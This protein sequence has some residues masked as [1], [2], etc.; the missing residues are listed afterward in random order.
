MHHTWLCCRYLLLI[1]HKLQN[2][3]YH[4]AVFCIIFFFIRLAVGW[5]TVAIS[6]FL[7]EDKPPIIRHENVSNLKF[8]Q[9]KKQN[10]I[11]YFSPQWQPIEACDSTFYN[12]G[13]FNGFI[14]NKQ[15]TPI[16]CSTVALCGMHPKKHLKVHLSSWIPEN[17]HGR[18]VHTCSNEF[19][20]QNVGVRMHNVDNW[21]WNSLILHY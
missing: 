16:F 1:L 8:L 2:V 4:N 11:S 17:N 14:K 19:C 5:K 9:L 13:H 6:S 3:W 18:K 20:C 10:K 21:D 15:K 7:T 12:R